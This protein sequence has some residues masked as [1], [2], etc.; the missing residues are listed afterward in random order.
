MTAELKN[1]YDENNGLEE[2]KDSNIL[3]KTFDQWGQEMDFLL[4]S[5]KPE[6]SFI[7]V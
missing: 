5:S 6:D 4:S 3:V 1:I 7:S 2:V